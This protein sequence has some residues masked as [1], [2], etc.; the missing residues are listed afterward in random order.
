M[1]S[2]RNPSLRKT[3]AQRQAQMHGKFPWTRIKDT[4]DLVAK[5]GASAA[6]VLAAYVAH[7]FQS[8]A[9][10]STLLQQRE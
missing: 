10:V 3:S 8:A 5:L 6:I 9:N 7:N 4:V 1:Q 2:V